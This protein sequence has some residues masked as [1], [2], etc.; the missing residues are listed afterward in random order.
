L[1]LT[2][3]SKELNRKAPLIVIHG[4]PKTG[5]TILALSISKYFGTGKPLDDVYHIGADMDA[6][7]GCQE[8][9]LEVPYAC[10]VMDAFE[11]DSGRRRGVVPALGA[12]VKEVEESPATVKWCIT[13][14]ASQLDTIFRNYYANVANQEKWP[15]FNS[16]LN[17]HV[18][19]FNSLRLTGMGL[20]VLCHSKVPAEQDD[21]QLRL[22]ANSATAA[23]II[24]SLTGQARDLYCGNCSL[25][26]AY[27]NKKDPKTK[28][29]TRILYPMGTREWEGGNRWGLT[30]EIENPN[31]RDILERKPGS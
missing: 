15:L 26:G 8:L 31:L 10:D 16:C 12:I 7:A 24:P 9:N 23:N 14:T 25:E 1:G 19:L 30:E 21:T 3:S 2:K 13:D 11:D 6:L 4:P 18:R 5:K 17:A 22:K 28:E 27:M 29:V 20:I